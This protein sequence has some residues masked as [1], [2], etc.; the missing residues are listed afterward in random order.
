MNLHG[1]VSRAIGAVNPPEA[2]TISPSSGYT[3]RADGTR[4]PSYGTPVAVA[5]QIQELTQRDIYQT[6][7]LNLQG[8]QVTMYLPGQWAGA[9][10]ADGKGGDIITRADGSIWLVAAILELWP[11]WCKVLAVL[12]DNS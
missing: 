10:R 11:N 5:A 12:Q 4:T 7:G 6:S 2:I 9:I 8:V 3:T 1:I